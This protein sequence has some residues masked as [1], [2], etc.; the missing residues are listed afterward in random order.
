VT[1]D[2]FNITILGSRCGGEHI[3]IGGTPTRPA[4]VHIVDGTLTKIMGS[5]LAGNVVIEAVA[6]Q[7]FIDNTVQL[8]DTVID[9]GTNTIDLSARGRQVY[10]AGGGY[11][12]LLIDAYAPGG[13]AIGSMDNLLRLYG[14]KSISAGATFGHNLA[15]FVDI[16]DTSTTAQV[17]FPTPE[18]DAYFIVQLTAAVH[19]GSVPTDAL[20]VSLP[21]IPVATGFGI[22][23]DAAPGAGNKV[24]IYWMVMRVG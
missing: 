1:P 22:K 24:R 21:S 4:N 3:N 9:H 13:P 7:T 20:R 5:S 10:K 15:G 18:P 17:T 11:E 12:R 23:L 8:G 16:A 19:N 14:V 2:S 6:D